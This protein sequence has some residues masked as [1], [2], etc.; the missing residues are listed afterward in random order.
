MKKTL[1]AATILAVLSTPALA[2]CYSDGIRV[3][4]VQKFSNKGYVNKSW[5]GELVMEGTQSTSKT[6]GTTRTTNVWKFSVLDADVAKVIDEATMSGKPVALKYCQ[7]SPVT[8]NLS[9]DTD[10]RITKAVIRDTK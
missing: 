6:N 2:D 1:L 4:T 9:T 3:G 7:L 8:P 10:Y 5:E